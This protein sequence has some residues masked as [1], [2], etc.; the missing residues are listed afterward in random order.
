MT[1]FSQTGCEN[2]AQCLDVAKVNPDLPK[3]VIQI[4]NSDGK[5]NGLFYGELEIHSKPLQT[6]G[7]YSITTDEVT[8]E[9][10]VLNDISRK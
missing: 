8:I 3:A 1:I 6:I 5:L 10:S 4:Y 2:Q 7:D 9:F